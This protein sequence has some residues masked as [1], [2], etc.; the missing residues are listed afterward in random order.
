MTLYLPVLLSSSQFQQHLFPQHTFPF[1]DKYEEA[2][3]K[4]EESLKFNRKTKAAAAVYTNKA[5]C[6]IFLNKPEEALKTSQ[7]AK[8]VDD[9]WVKAYVREAQAYFELKEYGEAAAT[10][11][12]ALKLEPS[13]G[14]IKALFNEAVKKGK[15]AHAQKKH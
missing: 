14:D 11:F 7:L 12:D 10:Y 9:K 8:K 15:Q 13:N 4:Y 3:A 6:E 1:L 5:I 2:L